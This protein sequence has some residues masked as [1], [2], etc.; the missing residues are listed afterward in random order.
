[1]LFV[2]YGGSDPHLEDLTEEL[3]Y[4]FDFTAGKGMARNYLVVNKGSYGPILEHYKERMRTELI[5]VD[6]NFRKSAKLL[7][8]LRDAAPR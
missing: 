7:K 6:D 1:M 4:F 3:C 8:G 2:G 5:V